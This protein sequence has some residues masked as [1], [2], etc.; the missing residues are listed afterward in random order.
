MERHTGRT[1]KYERFGGM[2]FTK[3]AS[4]NSKRRAEL[5]KGTLMRQGYLVRVEPESVGHY[6]IYRRRK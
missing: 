5:K 6:N 2:R 4:A 1:E 3:V